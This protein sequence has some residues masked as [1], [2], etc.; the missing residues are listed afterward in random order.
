M[1][2]WLRPTPENARC[3]WTALQALGAPVGD[4]TLAELSTPDVVVQIGVPPRRI[5]L[6]TSIAGVEFDDAWQSRE[7]IVVSGQTVPFLSF[8]AASYLS[9]TSVPP[10]PRE[11]QPMPTGWNRALH[12]SLIDCPRVVL[13]WS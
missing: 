8:S 9:P 13:L 10:D 12:P 5:D 4:L 6:L 11:T 1:D 3:V 7:T 2:I